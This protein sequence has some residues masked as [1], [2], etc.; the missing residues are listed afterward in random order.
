[1]LLLPLLAAGATA[2]PL[3]AAAA[4]PAPVL[5]A[6]PTGEAC[7]DDA[8][9]T[10]VVDLTDLGGEVEVGCA[11]GTPASG[12]QALADAGFTDTRDSAQM[13]C[14]IDDLPNPCPTTFEGS[15][16]SYWSAEADGEWVAYEVGADQ[17]TPQPGAVEGWRYFDGSA[18][19]TVTPAEA[20]ATA[21]VAQEDEPGDETGSDGAA[22]DDAG[23]TPG[24]EDEPGSVTP[25]VLGAALA[26]LLVAAVVGLTRRR[27]D[28][29]GPGGQD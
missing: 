26:V 4:A 11:E 6:V 2:L 18:G 5:T 25:L 22:A 20:L 24:D 23:T 27:R 17:S 9:V 3:T 1:M 13:I 7:A 21:E 10:V 14:A 29:H 28:P 15:W 19:P 12:A 8:G 16:W